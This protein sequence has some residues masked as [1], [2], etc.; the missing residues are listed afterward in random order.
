MPMWYTG[1]VHNKENSAPVSRTG[2]V[3]SAETSLLV[4]VTNQTQV[5]RLTKVQI[6]DIHGNIVRELSLSAVPGQLD[7]Y[8]V[9]KFIPPTEPFYLEVCGEDKGGNPI[10]R[11]SRTTVTP[12]VPAPP[13]LTVTATSALTRYKPFDLKCHVESLVP[14]TISWLK[15]EIEI[16]AEKEFNQSAE[17][18]LHLNNM[19]KETEGFYTCRARN[20]A[21]TASRRTLLGFRP[22]V[23]TPEKVL[24]KVGKKEEIPC[25]IDSELP[26]NLTWTVQPPSGSSHLVSGPRFKIQETGS[27]IIDPVEIG[28]E[29]TYQCI[30]ENKAGKSAKEVLVAVSESVR[31]SVTP[32]KLNFTRGKSISLSCSATGSP[33]LYLQW[34][35]N[36]EVIKATDPRL[37]KPANNTLNLLLRNL[38][39]SS[40]GRY[41]C[42]A[43]NTEGRDVG[44]ADLVYEEFPTVTLETNFLEVLRGSS[45]LLKCATTGIP[46]PQVSWSVNGEKITPSN[47]FLFLQDGSLSIPAVQ[48]GGDFKCTAQNKVG[49]DEDSVLLDVGSVPEFLQQ[50]DD[51]RLKILSNGIIQCEMAGTPKPTVNWRRKDGKII[52]AR[53]FSID[54]NTCSLKVTDAGVEDEGT[55]VVSVENKFGKRET[56]VNVII[57]GIV[58]PVLDESSEP[59]ITTTLNEFRELRC[60]VLQAYPPP[61]IKW[62]KDGGLVDERVEDIKVYENGSLIISHVTPK[63]EGNYECEVSNAGGTVK[64][65]M[66]IAILEIPVLERGGDPSITATISEFRELRCEVLQAYPPPTIK[67]FKDGQLID[68]RTENMKVYT[69]GSLIIPYVTPKDEGNYECEVSNAGGTVKKSMKITV[70]G[71]PVLDRSGDPSITKVVGEFQEL[72]CEVLQAYPP[73]TIKW[74]KD[75]ELVDEKV[76]NVKVYDNGSLIIPYVTAKNEGN[77]ECEVSNTGGAA[78]K[79][80]KIA[81]L[82]PPIL[83][84]AKQRL[85]K[86]RP[87]KDVKLTC[88]AQG[89]PKPIIIW[90]KDNADI[91]PSKH[92]KQ[93][94]RDGSLQIKKVTGMDNGTYQCIASNSAGVREKIISLLVQEPPKIAPGKEEV[95]AVMNNSITLECNV[96]AYPPPEVKWL[97]NG[98]PLPADHFTSNQ[99]NSISFIATPSDAGQYECIATNIAGQDKSVTNV[100]VMVPPVFESPEKE[101]VANQGQDITLVCNADSVPPAEYFWYSSSQNVLEGDTHSS[102]LILHDVQPSSA[103]EYICQATNGAGS[104]QKMFNLKVNDIPKINSRIPER[105]DLLQGTDFEMQCSADGSAKITWKKDGK[106]LPGDSHILKIKDATHDDS[107]LY[108]CTA[109]N[110]YGTD[111]KSMILYVL[112]PPVMEEKTCVTEVEDGAESLLISCPAIEAYPPPTISWYKDGQYI[113]TRIR[114]SRAV[115][116]DEDRSLEIKRVTEDDNGQ[117]TCLA[118]NVAGHSTADITVK[119]LT[120]PMFMIHRPQL[121]RDEVEGASVTL[122]CSVTG[123]P[124]PQVTWYRN[125]HLL[126]DFMV[127]GLIRLSKNQILQIPSVKLADVGEYQCVAENKVGSAERKFHLEVHELGNTWNDSQVPQWTDWSP[128]SSCSSS[129]GK[130]EMVRIRKCSDESVSCSG[131]HEEWKRCIKPDCQVDGGWNNWSPWSEC[132]ATCG[133]GQRKRYRKCYN[134]PPSQGGKACEGNKEQY[135]SCNMFP[136]PVGGAWSKWSQWESCNGP[137]YNSTRRRTRRC[138]EPS[139]AFGGDECEGPWAQYESCRHSDCPVSGQWSAWSPWSS[140]S[141]SCGPSIRKRFRTC[142]HPGSQFGGHCDGDHIQV[143]KCPTGACDNIPMQASV[144]LQGSLNGQTLSDTIPDID[145]LD[146]DSQRTVQVSTRDVLKQQLGW[147]PYLQYFV[148]PL[149]WI[150]AFQ[151]DGASNGHT[152]THGH[153]TQTMQILFDSGEKLVLKTMCHGTGSGNK[154]HLHITV[155]GEVPLLPLKATTNIEPYE[156]DYVQTGPGEIFA[157]SSGTVEADGDLTGYKWNKTITYNE[158]KMMPY[159]VETLTV[160]GIENELNPS[161]QRMTLKISAMIG[162]KAGSD[163]CPDGYL[164][165]P[166]AQFCQDKDECID[167]RLNNCHITQTCEN[168]SGSYYCACPPGLK[169]AGIG[170]PCLDIDECSVSPDLCSH[171]CANTEGGFKCLCPPGLVLLDDNVTCSDPYNRNVRG[172]GHLDQVFVG[173]NSCPPGFTE[174][175]GVCQEINPCKDSPITCSDDEICV[176]VH[177]W[178]RCLSAPCPQG[179]TRDSA[180]KNC[181]MF[182]TEQDSNCDSGAK[183]TQTVKYMVLTPEAACIPA[184]WNITSLP[185]WE[186]DNEIQP[187]TSC[188][189]KENDNDEGKPFRVKMDKG[190]GILYSNKLLPSGKDYRVVVETQTYDDNQQE[191][192]NST[193]YIILIRPSEDIISL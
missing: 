101:V 166:D 48:Y 43:R 36:G 87:G 115:S 157:T 158:G 169:A 155:D 71:I 178:Y 75:G 76:E 109:V 28:D 97:K 58:N 61:T 140:C 80:V 127:K 160:K 137:C 13:I 117:Y 53:R 99:D 40:E 95:S 156:E 54:E 161:T 110:Q 105:E 45:V 91:T 132:T 74:F 42:E 143:E 135:E 147:F 136:C 29:G 8:R 63:S 120:K 73:P 163:S 102:T 154:I 173:P 133:I 88:S 191:I 119:I 31:V 30:A 38:N 106:T 108:T 167:P 179:Y 16:S 77:Y 125:G 165:Q 126:L 44:V 184:Y 168:H 60:E 149:V 130:S 24:V 134:P 94:P 190:E 177:G 26:Y 159:L 81:V 174:Q 78:K 175:D 56:E 151:K 124:P 20:I 65:I 148:S 111:Y 150:T 46:A 32:N 121:S 79:M 85:V 55:Y 146:L 176:G 52:D 27:L 12:Q 93:N 139:P 84:G 41:E 186:E 122:D 144:Q 162:K 14:I 187:Q 185:V 69:N 67:W 118:S 189:I 107:G 181:L 123:Y 72:T 113:D 98:I 116:K 92:I 51:A 188:R 17:V 183:L 5:S 2:S 19:T 47:D 82:E 112:V 34:S 141:A 145:V 142:N 64:K 131:V 86:A 171:Y 57:D 1:A 15:D 68:E 182:C 170:A 33:E 172:S 193:K 66:K 153:F 128:W 164:F 7:L 49:K 18:V 83:S 21:G 103:G 59:I 62:F 4:R 37:R 6:K 11:T 138:T 10:S 114:P 152:L 25:L 129:C 23:G 35:K 89:N 96:A 180:T 22:K 50:L 39:N 70:F 3:Q 100:V 9:D 90:K 192:L 104:S